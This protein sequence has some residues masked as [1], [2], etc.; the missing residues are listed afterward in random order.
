F[1]VARAGWVAH[2]QDW[3]QRRFDVQNRGFGGYN[4]R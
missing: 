1:E 4:S 2:L 3:Y